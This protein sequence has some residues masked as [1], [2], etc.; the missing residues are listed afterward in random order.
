MFQ[1]SLFNIRLRDRGAPEWCVFLN[2][3]YDFAFVER[4]FGNTVFN[5]FSS[6][7]GFVSFRFFHFLYFLDFLSQILIWNLNVCC[8]LPTA[9]Q[10]WK[11]VFAM[12]WSCFQEA[13]LNFS[14]CVR[15]NWFIEF[16][17]LKNYYKIVFKIFVSRICFS[18]H[19]DAILFESRIQLIW[20]DFFFIYFENLIKFNDVLLLLGN[21]K[22]YS[23][24]FVCVCVRRMRLRLTERVALFG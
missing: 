11:I 24:A 20:F 22:S 7:S 17:C 15:Y 13:C 10:K 21:F 4:E 2:F 5:I 6:V 9:L 8:G 12:W 23:N 14:R 1:F 19:H 18:C 16:L 3:I